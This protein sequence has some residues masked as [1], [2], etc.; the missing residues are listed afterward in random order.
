MRIPLSES[1]VVEYSRRYKY[2]DDSELVRRLG[3]ARQRG[4]LKRDDLIKVAE[5]KWRGG[6]VR[7]LVS[8]NSEADVKE[9]TAA[10]FATQNER[11]RIGA[12]LSLSGVD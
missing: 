7:Q 9:I 11:L 8:E 10:A 12:L 1:Q 3:E 2:A 4:F 5:W 6:R